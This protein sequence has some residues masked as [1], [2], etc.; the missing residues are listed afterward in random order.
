MALKTRPDP[1]DMLSRVAR[2][3]GWALAF[4]ILTV[5][6]GVVALVWPG[7]T[8]VVLA[9]LFGIQLII[10]G[11]FRFVAA[12]AF[13]MLSGGTRVLMALLG[14]LSLIIGIYA[15]R[16]LAVS[17]LALGL[18]LGIYWVVSGTTELFTAISVK[19]MSGRGWTALMGVLSI[20]AGLI[21]VSYPGISLVTLAVIVSVWLLVFGF[22]EIA[23]AF[24]L[25]RLG[26]AVRH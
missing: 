6:L 19:D 15:V 7:R 21:L 11:I 3:W 26:H 5:A 8:L 25:R 18:L 17:L 20:I 2:N 4:G 13:D 12:F 16:H 9:V 1:A 23:L 22:G 10:T 14:V 24:Q